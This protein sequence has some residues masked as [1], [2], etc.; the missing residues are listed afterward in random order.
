MDH[1]QYL[2][3][4]DASQSLPILLQALN[5]TR[6]D[7]VVRAAASIG[8]LGIE[9]DRHLQVVPLHVIGTLRVIGVHQVRLVQVE[10]T[11]RHRP[12]GAWLHCAPSQD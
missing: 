1:L 2:L 8:L 11:Q 9:P 6:K 7:A 4:P 5:A 3:H 12:N 10:C